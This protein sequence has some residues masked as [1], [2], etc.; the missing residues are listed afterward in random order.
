MMSTIKLMIEQFNFD[1]AEHVRIAGMP[2]RLKQGVE[3]TNAGEHRYLDIE[4]TEDYS[5]WSTINNDQTEAW[6]EQINLREGIDDPRIA[7]RLLK[8]F[9]VAASNAGI[10]QLWMASAAP[11]D[12]Y[13]LANVFGEQNITFYDTVERI[14]VS[15]MPMTLDQALDSIGRVQA[16]EGLESHPLIGYFDVC[17]GMEVIDITSWEQPRTVTG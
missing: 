15:L 7:E 8:G 10:G 17:V 5:I 11:S 3:M 9:A 1:E 6:I 14:S 13:L 12:L 2:L 4:I 16:L